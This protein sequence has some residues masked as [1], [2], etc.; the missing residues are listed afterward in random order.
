M[1]RL[2]LTTA[3]AT[4]LTTPTATGIDSDTPDSASPEVLPSDFS[5]DSANAL[6][7]GYPSFNLMGVPSPVYPQCPPG[8]FPDLAMCF[9]PNEATTGPLSEQDSLILSRPLTA[10]PPT[11]HDLAENVSSFASEMDEQG[12]ITAAVGAPPGLEAPLNTPSQGSFLHSMGNCRPCPWFYKPSGCRDG[13][14]CKYCHVCPD[15]EL[16]FRKKIK[17]AARRLGLMMPTRL[18][19][20]LATL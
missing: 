9:S 19:L 2:G 8:F 10:S 20:T 7:F 18:K 16:K 6:N 3:A 15:G 11:E 4:G 1:L 17:Q 12:A 14:G 5:L 13:Q